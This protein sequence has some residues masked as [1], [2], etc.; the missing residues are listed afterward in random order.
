M[1]S[2]EKCLLTEKD[3]EMEQGLK[4]LEVDKRLVVLARLDRRVEAALCFYL[5]EVDERQ[6]YS[7]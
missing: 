4:A 1:R 6:L 2:G 5:H 3:L 7:W